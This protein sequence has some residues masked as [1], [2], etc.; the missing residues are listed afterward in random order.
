MNRN[1]QEHFAMLP[2]VNIGRSKFDRGFTHT[3]TFN[4][5]ELVPVYVDPDIVPGDT[6]TMRQSEII[7]MT[8]PICPVMDNAYMDFYWFFVPN[9]LVMNDWKKLM[10]E[11][12][13]APWT[14]TVEV[15]I[16]QVRIDTWG[17]EGNNLTHTVKKVQY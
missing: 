16:P 9:R 3:T 10:G 12:E 6:V 17:K 15:T 1:T 8:T 11:N 13:T 7:R 4:T 2:E 5:G 14:Q